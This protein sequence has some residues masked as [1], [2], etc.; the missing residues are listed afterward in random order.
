METTELYVEYIIIGMETFLW[1]T[2]GTFLI[3]GDIFSDIISYC[4]TN[5][6]PSIMTI[7]LC[8]ILGLITDRVADLFFEKRKQKIKIKY[9]TRCG[10]S[11]IV[12]EKYSNS[13]YA[14]F[15]LSRIR[16]LR[17]TVL[18]SLIIGFLGTYLGYKYYNITLATF[19]FFLACFIFFSSNFAHKDLLDNYYKK[20]S[21]LEMEN[22]ES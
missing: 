18:N 11:I 1:I 22:V 14:K 12:W 15:T 16:I 17:S 7:G 3:I 4:I 5:L 19:I 21:A 6:L 8:Y 20:T 9:T 2:M 10:T 13:T